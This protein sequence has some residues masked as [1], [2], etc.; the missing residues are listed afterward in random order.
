MLALTLDRNRIAPAYLFCGDHGCGKTTAARIF[1]KGLN[2]AASPVPTSNP[3]GECDSCRAIATGTDID[4]TEVD[5][6]SHN[7]VDF[8]RELREVASFRSARGRY[9][10][11]VLDECH[12]LTPQAQN[13]LLKLLEEPPA[14][15]VFILCTTDPQKMLDTVRGRCHEFRFRPAPGAEVEEL[16]RSIA[17]KEDIEIE[18]E[19]I[20]AIAKASN[21]GLRD[22]TTLL[23]QLALLPI[24]RSRDVYSAIGTVS[25]ADVLPIADA[26]VKNDFRKCVAATRAVVNAGNDPSDIIA[27]LIEVFHG[28][29]MAQAL[30]NEARP[31]INVADEDFDAIARLATR[32]TNVIA[33]LDRLRR[34]ASTLAKTSDK[35][36]AIWLEVALCEIIAGAGE[37][38]A[39]IVKPAP[40]PAP[41]PDPVSEFNAVGRSLVTQLAIESEPVPAPSPQLDPVGVELSRIMG[42]SAEPEP[43]KPPSTSTSTP[44]FTGWENLTPVPATPATPETTPDVAVTASSFDFTTVLAV[45]PTMAKVA[46][47]DNLVR[48]DSVGT[49][50]VKKIKRVARF[51]PQLIEAYTACGYPVSEVNFVEA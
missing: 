44:E 42:K 19:A 21:G 3:C 51:K 7:G 14:N 38:P 49:L 32:A 22:A 17:E 34:E 30:G 39:A 11:W 43:V 24:I 37:A 31:L 9:R 13:A 12:Q 35:Q 28:V 29:L 16:L 45:L 50:Y 4:V 48:A 1:S 10:V 15:V 47:A 27:T 2:C 23:G 20:A 33:T 40:L 25:V 41:S 6:A 18:D 46:I 8:A 5:A 26:Q 36:K